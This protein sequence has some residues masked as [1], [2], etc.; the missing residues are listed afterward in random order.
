MV[1]VTPKN[2]PLFVLYAHLYLFDPSVRSSE[3]EKKALEKLVKL[4]DWLDS[5]E[6][7][8]ATEIVSIYKKHQNIEVDILD[9]RAVE[10]EINRLMITLKVHSAVSLSPCIRRSSLMLDV[11]HGCILPLREDSRHTHLEAAAHDHSQNR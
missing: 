8:P 2:A 9:Q 11:G 3:K 6:P 7:H 10:A 5:L 4:F 1:P